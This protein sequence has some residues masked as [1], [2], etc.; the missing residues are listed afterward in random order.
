MG[1]AV[2]IF[3]P[4]VNSYHRLSQSMFAGNTF[5]WGANNRM[6]SVRIPVEGGRT[7][8]LEHRI[9]GAD[10]NPYLTLASMH[11]GLKNRID[12]GPPQDGD[13]RPAGGSIPTIWQGALDAME[14]AII[15]RNYLGSE[16]IDLYIT[17]KR[18]EMDRFYDLPMKLKYDWCLACR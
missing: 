5:S 3:A 7:R 10:A 17:T 11:R 15:L 16:Y 8:R 14:Q 18:G 13:Q 12:P 6:T 1:E 9:A 4:N 2:A